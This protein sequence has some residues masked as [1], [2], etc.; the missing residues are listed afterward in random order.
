[1]AEGDSV[2]WALVPMTNSL[3]LGCGIPFVSFRRSTGE[4]DEQNLETG[5]LSGARDL[6]HGDRRFARIRHMAANKLFKGTHVG[7]YCINVAKRCANHSGRV[8]C[9][10][11]KRFRSEILDRKAVAERQRRLLCSLWRPDNCGV[12]TI[13]STVP[14]PT[15]WVQT[16]EVTKR[17]TRVAESLR[18]AHG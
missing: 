2:E 15:V 5:F 11:N 8:C 14:L 18:D 1:V 13:Q 9:L 6:S 17:K 16:E 12:G 4:L 7:R 3:Q 10:G